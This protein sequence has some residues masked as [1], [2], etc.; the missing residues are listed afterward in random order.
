MSE[1]AVYTP[2]EAATILKVTRRTIYNWV[3]SKKLR[4]FKIGGSVRIREKDLDQ[5]MRRR[6]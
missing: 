2:A 3:R 1:P 5:P 6:V 4:A